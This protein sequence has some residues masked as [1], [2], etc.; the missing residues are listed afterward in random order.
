[1]MIRNQPAIYLPSQ[2]IRTDLDVYGENVR[3]IDPIDSPAFGCVMAICVGA[4]VVGSIHT[5]V[6]EGEHVKRGQEFGYFPFG[7]YSQIESLIS[8]SDTLCSGGS[9][10]VLL[11]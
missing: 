7:M 2:A 8:S 9:T 5:T 11:F 1:M 10:I 3:K 6:K 4:M